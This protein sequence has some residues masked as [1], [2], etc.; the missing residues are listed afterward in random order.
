MKYWKFNLKSDFSIKKKHEIKIKSS[1]FFKNIFDKETDGFIV[2]L[3]SKETVRDEKC[4][5]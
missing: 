2:I 4:F 3:I 5:L 1:L